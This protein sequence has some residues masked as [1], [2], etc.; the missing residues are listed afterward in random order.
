MTDPRPDWLTFEL[1][2]KSVQVDANDTSP[3]AADQHICDCNKKPGG[4]T[5]TTN[6]CYNYATLIE[7]SHC[8]PQCKNNRIS[9]GRS[10]NIEVRET[11]PKGHG[12]FCNEDIKYGQFIAEYV[13]ELCSTKEFKKRYIDPHELLCICFVI[14]L[15]T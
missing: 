12:L 1:I 6:A 11:L 4:G 13:G 9:T 2:S 5:C 15:Q 14:F 7:C 8:S 10:A 3:D